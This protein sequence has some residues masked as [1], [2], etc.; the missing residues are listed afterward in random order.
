MS[1][2]SFRKNEDGTLSFFPKADKNDDIRQA[3]RSEIKKE[4]FETSTSLSLVA[5]IFSIA[6]FVLVF[7]ARL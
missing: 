3:I 6:T 1:N 2:L 7:I 5:L 4:K